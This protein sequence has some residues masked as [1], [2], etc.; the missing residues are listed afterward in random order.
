MRTVSLSVFLLSLVVLP[1]CE[2]SD[3]DTQTP[4]PLA[5][6]E[7]FGPYAVGA[8]TVVMHDAA[9]DRELRVEV[10]YPATEAARADMATGHGVELFVPAGDDRTAYLDLLRKAPEPGPTR[11]VHQARGAAALDGEA[12]PTVMFSHCMNCTRFSLFN[13]AGY[14]ASHG[15]AFVA[16]DHA[17]GT[18]FDDLRGESASLD[19]AFLE[20]RA[21]D[22]SFVLDRILD[23]EAAELPAFLQGRFD[24]ERIGMA[25]H[26]FGAVTTG[27]VLSLD[28]RP[29]AGFP[30]AAPLESPLPEGVYLEDIDE[31][32]A[33]VVAVEDNSITELGN[34]LIR[35]NFEA[36]KAPA[37]KIEI[38]DAGHLSFTDICGIRSGFDPGCNPNHRA[39]VDPARDFTYIDL[40]LARNITAAYMAAFFS[41]TL[42]DDALGLQY[43]GADRSAAWVS[44]ESR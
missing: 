42:N 8:T 13:V 20:V 25:G 40:E 15:F 16:P 26:S 4:D 17:G 7:D 18:L 14:M 21:A 28:D 2:G 23:D 44:V 29:K 37:W 10:W 34:V 12:W 22:I 39:Q 38:A 36:A 43:L 32:L 1:A 30:I 31:P 33:F 19:S 24:G 35:Q 6:F 5:V 27:K 11:T 3:P 41:H 9:R